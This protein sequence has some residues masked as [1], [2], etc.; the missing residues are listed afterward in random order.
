MSLQLDNDNKEPTGVTADGGGKEQAAAG[1]RPTYF[2]WSARDDAADTAVA[3][4]N[5]AGDGESTDSSRR[6]VSNNTPGGACQDR[7][8]ANSAPRG[9]ADAVN[10]ERGARDDAAKNAG[11]HA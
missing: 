7:V 10:G 6:P 4:G 11:N 2:F 5:D 3:L 9:A 1:A 8:G